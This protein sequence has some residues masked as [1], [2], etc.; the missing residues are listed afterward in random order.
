[1][2]IEIYDKDNGKNDQCIIDK[3]K[4]LNDLYYYPINIKRSNLLLLG[5]ED[6]GEVSCFL[7]VN[8]RNGYWYFRG[9]Y[10][11]EEYRGKGYQ[12]KLRNKAI[13]RLKSMGINRVSSLVHTENKYSINNIKKLNFTITGRR[14][15]NYHIVKYI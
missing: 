10:V 6:S 12:I 3:V 1:M 11:K 7:G 13:D 5:Y 15:E 9:C 8:Q 2:K 4:P 14:K